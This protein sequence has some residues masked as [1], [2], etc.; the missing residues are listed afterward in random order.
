M[1]GPKAC[2]QGSPHH[3]LDTSVFGPKGFGLKGTDVVGLCEMQGPDLTNTC[4]IFHTCPPVTWVMTYASLSAGYRFWSA[5]TGNRTRV[6]RGIAQ[7]RYPYATEATIAFVD[8]SFGWHA[9]RIRTKKELQFGNS[10]K[11]LSKG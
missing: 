8:I 2:A 3:Q 7:T 5:A 11:T 9:C 1:V 6:L 4:P 10:R